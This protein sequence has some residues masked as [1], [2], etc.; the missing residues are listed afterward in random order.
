VSPLTDSNRRPPPYHFCVRRVLLKVTTHAVH[1]ADELHR[2]RFAWLIAARAS[3]R[4]FA[5]VDELLRAARTLRCLGGCSGSLERFELVEAAERNREDVL[6]RHAATARP[7]RS[8]PRVPP[9]T[10]LTRDCVMLATGG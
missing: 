4:K 3:A 9:R 6:G 10:I 8:H 2:D 1:V 7:R 5:A